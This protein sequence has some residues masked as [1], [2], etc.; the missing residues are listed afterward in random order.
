MT[1]EHWI[2]IGIAAFNGT[3]AL[4]IKGM[5]SEFKAQGAKLANHS[6]RLAVLEFRMS[7]V[8]GRPERREVG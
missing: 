4:F 5:Y 6:E 1:I 8:D 7:Q 3:I 2:G